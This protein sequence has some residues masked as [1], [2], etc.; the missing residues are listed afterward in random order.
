MSR[1]TTPIGTGTETLV[2]ARFL[3]L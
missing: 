2:F 3:P 1:S